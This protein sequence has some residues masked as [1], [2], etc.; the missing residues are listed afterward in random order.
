MVSSPHHP[1][2][3]ISEPLTAP[4][5]SHLRWA[6]REDGSGTRSEFESHLP[7]GLKASDLNIELTLPS[8]EAILTA[9]AAGTGVT[10]ISELAARPLIE[11]GRLVQLPLDLPE[12]PFYRLRHRERSLSRAAEA[13]VSA[14]RS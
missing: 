7:Q 1:L 10:A 8:N 3:N 4:D 13:F 2:A 5:L 11:A 6:L 12:R 9:V 14:L